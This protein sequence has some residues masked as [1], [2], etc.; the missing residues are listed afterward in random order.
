MQLSRLHYVTYQITICQ[1]LPAGEMAVGEEQLQLCDIMWSQPF[2]VSTPPSPLAIVLRP[3]EAH[4]V[5]SFEISD[6][7][8][9][10]EM[11]EEELDSSFV[12]LCR[13]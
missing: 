12:T 11:A 7:S 1:G 2:V 10:S 4:A 9:A 8:L 13:C 6:A 3:D 5:I